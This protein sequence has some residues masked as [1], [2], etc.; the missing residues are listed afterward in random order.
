MIYP[1]VPEPGAAQSALLAAEFDRFCRLPMPQQNT[2]VARQLFDLLQF[3]VTKSPYWQGRIGPL[4]S[5]RALTDLPVMTRQDLQQH[6]Q[7]MRSEPAIEDIPGVSDPL[8]TR[9][10]GSTGVPV[11]VLRHRALYPLMFHAVTLLEARWH[12]IDPFKTM[13]I[14]KDAPDGVQPH[15]GLPF[16][17]L[18]PTGKLLVKNLV[19]H[20][21]QTLWAWLNDQT[22]DYLLTTPSLLQR[23]TDL[24]CDGDYAPHFE[25]IL[26]FGEV[27]SD[28]LRAAC[29]EKFGA[30]LVDRYTC[31]ETGWIALQCPRHDHYHVLS[32]TCVVELVDEHNQPVPPGVPGRVLVT[33]LH[34]YAQPIIRYDIGDVAEAG[35]PCDCGLNL[36]V[37]KRIYGRQR[38]FLKLP[39]GS[40]Q[41]A[42]LTGE[43]WRQIAPVE[44][45]RLVQQ[46]NGMVEATVEASRSLL[47]HEIS[48]LEKMLQDRL[49]DQLAFKVR[50]VPK[51]NWDHRWK[52]IDVMSVCE[53]L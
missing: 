22:A 44:A 10:S 3:A 24:G 1:F 35:G 12:G 18:G 17:G 26:T 23:F 7:A 19:E 4:A 29:V 27:V 46:D 5:G 51:I 11:E 6:S 42:R 48:A 14:I 45:F 37:I 47:P 31:E 2:V 25:K 16:S 49:S 38:S 53:K 34:S 9:T 21:D 20:D 33:S 40:Q 13:A 8:L 15:W 52:R 50:Q 39:D 43:Y 41:L 30:R 28:S 32:P 36:P